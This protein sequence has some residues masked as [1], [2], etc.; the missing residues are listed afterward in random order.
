MSG[1]NYI[2]P[3]EKARSEFNTLRSMAFV[4]VRLDTVQVESDCRLSY[5]AIA[6]V[7][8]KTDKGEWEALL[9][10]KSIQRRGGEC[11]VNDGGVSLPGDAMVA[12]FYVWKS[13]HDVCPK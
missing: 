7:V 3:S 4:L 1:A 8:Q 13:L 9:K 11:I 12:F 5:G 2:M 10:I 6:F